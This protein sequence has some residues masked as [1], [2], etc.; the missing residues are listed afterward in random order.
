MTQKL[1]EQLNQLVA[2]PDV[3]T[4]MEHSIETRALFI[5]YPKE[6]NVSNFLAWLFNPNEGHG[7]GDKAL[8]ELINQAVISLENSESIDNRSKTSKSLANWDATKIFST[9]FSNA[10][11]QRELKTGNGKESIDLAVFDN[12]NKIAIF[13]ELK[14]GAKE[15]MRQTNDYHDD[16]V[17][18]VLSHSPFKNNFKAI[19][20]FMDSREEESQDKKWIALDYGWLVDFLNRQKMSPSIHEN[21]QKIL[22]EYAEF[23]DEEDQMHRLQKSHRELID[24]VVE[25]H[26][27]IL[28]H[29]N[30]EFK[31]FSFSRYLSEKPRGNLAVSQTYFQ[32]KKLWDFL[33]NYS[34]FEPLLL[35]VRKE[36]PDLITNPKQIRVF[37]NLA[38]WEENLYSEEYRYWGV[39]ISL[40]RIN[41]TNFELNSLFRIM[42][43]KPQYENSIREIFIK[44]NPDR[45]APS[46]NANKLQFPS[47]DVGG[48]K[49]AVMAVIQRIKDIDYHLKSIA[50]L[51]NDCFNQWILGVVIFPAPISIMTSLLTV[52]CHI[53]PFDWFGIGYF[54]Q[55]KYKP[56]LRPA[57]QYEAIGQFVQSLDFAQLMPSKRQRM[58]LD[59]RVKLVKR[60]HGRFEFISQHL[61]LNQTRLNINAAALIIHKILHCIHQH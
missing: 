28:N 21:N 43:F 3:R 18:N 15:R 51:Q 25:E 11:I 31:R 29:F 24:R 20:I 5:S 41:E 1:D 34:E 9:S 57:H 46:K 13:L 10:I 7:L 60:Y 8:K 36:F 45:K 40:K 53:Q 44:M 61:Q 37:Y 30:S 22:S 27:G 55:G 14:F 58:T 48:N 56:F 39:S 35:P 54:W 23:L 49:S 12:F 33:F 47:K 16:I 17:N 38:R 4:L 32:S 6:I 26:K 50:P 42:G 59:C 52:A 2:D 19:F